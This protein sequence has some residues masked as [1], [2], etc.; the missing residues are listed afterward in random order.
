[1]PAD[2]LMEA[3][4]QLRLRESLIADLVENLAR[5]AVV[6]AESRTEEIQGIN[7]DP[8]PVESPVQIAVVSE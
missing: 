4:C 7:P 6:P 2:A 8:V 1:M 5:I 3:P